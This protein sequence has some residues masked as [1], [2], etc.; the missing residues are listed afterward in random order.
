MLKFKAE[1]C[2]FA[3][4]CCTAHVLCEECVTYS[5]DKDF[6]SMFNNDV[7]VCGNINNVWVQ[8]NYSTIGLQSPHRNSVKHITPEPALSCVSSFFFTMT[9]RGIVEA[10]IFMDGAANSD[11]ITLF[12]N[13]YVPGGNHGVM[14]N[15]NNTPLQAGFVK[16]W[17]TLRVQV[18]GTN[19]YTG[20]I[21]LMGTASPDSIVLV[22]SF[23]YI[24][25]GYDEERCVIYEE[26]KD[27]ATTEIE[28]DSTTGANV[29]ETTEP[30]SDP[31][32]QAEP[33]LT[34]ETQA[35]VTEITTEVEPSTADVKPIEPETTSRDGGD[36]D[37]TT[38]P[39]VEEIT[40]PSSD[41][42]TI[43]EPEPDIPTTPEPDTP[44]PEPDIPTTPEPDT[45]APEPHIPTTP[46]PDTPAP[47]PDIPTT[48]EP[49]TPAP[50]PG[51]PTTPESDTPAPE[52][53]IPTTP[54]PDTSAPEPDIPTTPEPDTPAPEP[55]IPTT[56]EPDTP[57]PEPDTP[58]PEPGI[59]TTPEPDTPAPEPDI[60]TTPEPDTPMTPPPN[61]FTTQPDINF[62]TT[63]SYT[64]TTEENYTDSPEIGQSSF[65]TPLTIT[66]VVL[67]CFII[68][69]IVAVTFY[70]IGKRRS[71]RNE[72][73]DIDIDIDN[74]PKTI[75]VPRVKQ[76]Y[77]D[78][79]YSTSNAYLV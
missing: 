47:E 75:T 30:G 23:R 73:M 12:A 52:P 15:I 3:L 18:I 76:V 59:P 64:T 46:E 44:A 49:D 11:Q 79:P 7:G 22:D 13:Q 43:P 28:I 24:P 66:M 2:V 40:T 41:I 32:T 20:Y 50:E 78:P 69:V 48:P 68:L 10:K 56:P 5:F 71:V 21:T 53:S 65:W 42:P 67:L 29:D 57:A 27:P 16:G 31:T 35:N 58:A 62:E 72:I 70:E 33:V 61:V 4:L 1:Q 26:D 9:G 37:T 8:R 14:G 36:S 34:T 51:I 63:E 54:E 77:T 17:H 39:S 60:P 19:A 38:Q 74:L 45:P 25:P 6:D 55:G